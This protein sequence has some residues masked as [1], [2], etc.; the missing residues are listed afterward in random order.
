MRYLLGI[1]VKSAPNPI[2]KCPDLKK[3]MDIISTD[4]LQIYIYDYSGYCYSD[5]YENIYKKKVTANGRS[6]GR[7]GELKDIS[8][9]LRRAYTLESKMEIP[10]GLPE[11]I[12][13]FA[14]Y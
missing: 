1:P 8:A 6:I 12:I 4:E 11:Y 3:C 7:E 5:E 2:P 13:R 10:D 14:F 9:I